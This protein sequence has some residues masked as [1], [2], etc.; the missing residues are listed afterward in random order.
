MAVIYSLYNAKPVP[1]HLMAAA[2]RN[3]GI[4]C[5]CPQNA[6]KRSGKEQRTGGIFLIKAKCGCGREYVIRNYSDP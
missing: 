2:A 6:R 3:A 4:Q 1:P 5:T